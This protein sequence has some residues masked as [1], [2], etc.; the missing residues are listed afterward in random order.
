MLRI[1]IKRSVVGNSSNLLSLKR[2]FV[3]ANHRVLSAIAILRQMTKPTDS[4]KSKYR[5]PY[6][7]E[8]EVC[9]IPRFEL[10]A[11][12]PVTRSIRSRW[13]FFLQPNAQG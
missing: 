13:R 6:S 9:G 8:P 12:R 7:H 4:E 11:L 5:R 10:K 3:L 2:D 1:Y